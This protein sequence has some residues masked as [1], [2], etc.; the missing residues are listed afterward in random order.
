MKKKLHTHI[1]KERERVEKTQK[2]LRHT[3]NASGT[4]YL[5]ASN[6]FSVKLST[7]LSCECFTWHF[8][9]ALNN[10]QFSIDLESTNVGLCASR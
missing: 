7:S 10:E 2:L 8:Y 4:N 9:N 1:R 5:H 3:C 6:D